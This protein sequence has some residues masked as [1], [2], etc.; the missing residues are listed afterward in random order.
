M[1]ELLLIGGGGHC[2]SCI[3]VIENINDFKIVGI[4]DNKLFGKKKLRYGY[5]ILGN[6][7][8]LI[9][10]SRKYKNAFVAVGQ[11]KTP[12]IRI[13]IYESL[14]KLGFEI[15]TIISQNSYVSSRSEISEGTIVM[16]GCII[17]AGVKILN[18]CIINNHCLIDHGSLI[19]SH[20][21]IS[22]GVKVN[23]NCLIGQG[24]FIGSGAI[25][26]QDSKVLPNS[27]IPAGTVIKS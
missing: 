17:N 8:D 5:P 21:H 19:E 6:D 9:K 13:N 11:I 7:S 15:C 16:H 3:D 1:T 10:L 14:K 24:S 27:I 20:C 23:G 18:N 22:T 12:S 4:V 26:F 2:L 25:I